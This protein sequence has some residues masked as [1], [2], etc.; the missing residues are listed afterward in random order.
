LQIAIM[1]N[2]YLGRINRIIFNL[3]HFP[4]A[5][6][7]RKARPPAKHARRTGEAG[8]CVSLAVILK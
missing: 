2:N 5:M 6:R 1:K 3:S 7:D 8:G 4:P